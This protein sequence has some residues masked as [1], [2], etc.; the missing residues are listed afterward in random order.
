MGSGDGF[1][2]MEALGG[3]IL[4]TTVLKWGVSAVDG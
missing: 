3:A 4:Q 1:G 2:T